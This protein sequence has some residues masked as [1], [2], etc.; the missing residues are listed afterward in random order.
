VPR[1]KKEW[2]YTSTTTMRHH[3]VLGFDSHR[4]LGIFLFT[5]ASRPALGPAQPPIQWVQRPLS[6]GVKRPGHEADRSPPS[7]LTNPISLHGVLGFDFLRE[8]GIFLFTTSR[9]AL[10]PTQ[11]PIQWISG[12]IFLGVNQPGREADHSLPSSVKVKE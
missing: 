2:G 8:L 1:S 4:E 12:I 5:N 11:P 7:I 3:E 10:G 9:T 6:L